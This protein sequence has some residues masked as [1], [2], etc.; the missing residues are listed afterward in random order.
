MAEQEVKREARQGGVLFEHLNFVFFGCIGIISSCNAIADIGLSSIH[1]NTVMRMYGND[2]VGKASIGD[3]CFHLEVLKGAQVIREGEIHHCK[4]LLEVVLN[5]RPRQHE[6]SRCTARLQCARCLRAQRILQSCGHCNINVSAEETTDGNRNITLQ[7]Q[8]MDS[9]S[10][11]AL[12]T[13]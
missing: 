2:R 9:H 6:A 10:P 12:V 5:G 1:G 13:D 4:E 8:L 7:Q 11:M 3:A